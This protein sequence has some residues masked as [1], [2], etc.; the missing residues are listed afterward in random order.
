VMGVSVGSAGGSDTH[1]PTKDGI[2]VMAQLAVSVISGNVSGVLY[3]SDWE[4][5]RQHAK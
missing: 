3:V 1:M 2:W 4:P 5:E